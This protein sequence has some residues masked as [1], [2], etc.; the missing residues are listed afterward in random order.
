MRTDYWPGSGIKKSTD[1]AFTQRPA[2]VF[3][4]DQ[5]EKQRVTRQKQIGTGYVKSQISI[6]PRGASRSDAIR[7]GGI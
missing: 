3:A 4:N 6:E 7:R 1:N 2:S 5:V